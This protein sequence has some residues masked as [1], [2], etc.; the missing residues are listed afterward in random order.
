VNLKS[1]R[2]VLGR[3]RLIEVGLILDAGKLLATLAAPFPLYLATF[4]NTQSGRVIFVPF[5][6]FGAMIVSGATP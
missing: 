3:R 2:P 4:G 6:N 1:S 5:T